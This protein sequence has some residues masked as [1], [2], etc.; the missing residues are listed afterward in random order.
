MERIVACIECGGTN[1]KGIFSARGAFIGSYH[2]LECDQA[3]SVIAF[4]DVEAYEKYRA[5]L[6]RRSE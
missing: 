3:V 4:D 2:C 6:K 1:L 5:S